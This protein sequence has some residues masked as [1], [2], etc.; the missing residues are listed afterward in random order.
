MLATTPQLSDEGLAEY[1]FQIEKAVVYIGPT[2]ARSAE[3]WSKFLRHGVPSHLELETIRQ[4]V[5]GYCV[6][7]KLGQ[8]A[9]WLAPVSARPNKPYS[10][11]ALA[12][13]GE[14]PFAL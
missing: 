4:Q 10:T 11:I 12:V 7:I 14:I 8:T 13:L 3:V 1:L 6:A 2:T 9:R 5:E